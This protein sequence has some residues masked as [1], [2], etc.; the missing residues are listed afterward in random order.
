[1]AKDFEITMNKD[2][3]TV[4]A[5]KASLSPRMDLI[6]ALAKRRIQQSAR[7]NRNTGDFIDSIKVTRDEYKDGIIDRVIYS[8]D[9]GALAIEAGYRAPDG[10]LVPG[11]HHFRNVLRGGS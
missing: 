11:Q 10:T 3:A 7:A 8:D 1:M 6:A 5:R 9:P 4:A 2:A